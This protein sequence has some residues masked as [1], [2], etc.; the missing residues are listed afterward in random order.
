MA[1]VCRLL[2]GVAAAGDAHDE[3]DIVAMPTVKDGDDNAASDGLRTGMIINDIGVR[4]K[5]ILLFVDNNET[6]P[7]AGVRGSDGVRSCCNGVLYYLG[8]ERE[9]CR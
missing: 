4:L 7:P 1:E 9:R 8:E 6:P 5:F 3:A 2:R